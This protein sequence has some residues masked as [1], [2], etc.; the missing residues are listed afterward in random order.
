MDDIIII[1]ECLRNARANLVSTIPNRKSFMKSSRSSSTGAA[2][3][4]TINGLNKKNIIILVI[5]LMILMDY[6]RSSDSLHKMQQAVWSS[7]NSSFEIMIF[8]YLAMLFRSLK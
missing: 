5:C 8:Y 7:M 3:S 6:C 4:F 2:Y 1:E